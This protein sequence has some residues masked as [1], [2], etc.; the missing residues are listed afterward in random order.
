MKD[1]ILCMLRESKDL[2][3]LYMDMGILDLEYILLML[4]FGI[5][6]ILV[7]RKI[8]VLL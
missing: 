4:M 8:F 2:L 1:L 3:V 5:L 7:Y 6:R